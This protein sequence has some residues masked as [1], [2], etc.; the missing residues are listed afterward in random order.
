MPTWAIST[1]VLCSLLASWLAS[2]AA[3]CPHSKHLP[4]WPLLTLLF[5]A[6]RLDASLSLKQINQ[7]TLVLHLPGI[8][9]WNCLR[10]TMCELSNVEWPQERNATYTG[11][12]PCPAQRAPSSIILVWRSYQECLQSSSCVFNR[13]K[14]LR[15]AALTGIHQ[16]ETKGYPVGSLQKQRKTGG[17]G[18]CVTCIQ[19][20]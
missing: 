17:L 11:V 13:C 19:V 4:F 5:L 3:P 20:K 2:V 7:P 6:V 8:H 9:F 16:I 12:A 1:P 15:I 10:T 14:R 18:P